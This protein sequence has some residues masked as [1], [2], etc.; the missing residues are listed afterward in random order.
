MFWAALFVVP[1]V[2]MVKGPRLAVVVTSIVTWVLSTLLLSW[3]CPDPS[4]IG[5]VLVYFFVVMPIVGALMAA[6]I[7]T[8]LAKGSFVTAMALAFFAWLAGIGVAVLVGP[9]SVL[10]RY[11]W[12]YALALALPA[13]YA[14]CGAVIGARLGAGQRA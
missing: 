9:V 3:L 6:A 12:D 2:V 5:S 7:A 13:V 11:T 4:H 10:H 8:R 1:V 14:S